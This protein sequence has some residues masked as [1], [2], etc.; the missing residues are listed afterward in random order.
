LIHELQHAT[1]AQLAKKTFDL[2]LWVVRFD[3]TTGIIK[4][5]HKETEQVKQLLLSLSSI[6]GKHVMV[7]TLATSGTIHGLS[8]KKEQHMNRC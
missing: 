5:L 3:G 1:N 7:T 6:G 8:K 2:G 4:C